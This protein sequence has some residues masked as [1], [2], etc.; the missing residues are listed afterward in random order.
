MARFESSGDA[1]LI[2][3]GPE[4]LRLEAWGDDSLRVRAR[5]MGPIL[6]WDWALLPKPEVAQAVS[7]CI[8]E[9]QMQASITNGWITAEVF[10]DSWFRN[11][12]IVYRNGEGRELL[13]EAGYQGGWK[14]RCRHWKTLSGGCSALKVTFE[15]DPEEK[16]F[17]MGEYQTEEL[18]RKNCMLSLS[19]H[20]TQASV[21][22]VISSAGYGF[23]W[24]NPAVGRA[25]FA[26]NFMEW[27]A[28]VTQQMD[29]W[30]TAGNTPRV[31]EHAFARVVG[32]APMM[33]E[34]GLGFWQS[35]LRYW[36]QEQ[37]LE[38]AREYRR[39]G[40]PL[41]VIACDFFHWRHMG[42]FR[43]EEEFFPDPAAM[44]RELKD[45]GT[46]LMVSVWPQISLRSENY[47]EM[48]DEGLLVRTVR[49]NPVTMQFPEDSVFLDATNPRTRAYVWE[50]CRKHYYDLG[51]RVFWLDEAEPEYGVYDF[52][53]Y[54]YAEGTA[55]E[56]S[57]IYPQRFARAF[58][59]GQQAQGQKE[60]VNLIRC[61]WAGSQRYGA[62]VW[63]GDISSTWES[64]RRQ[65]CAGLSISLAGIPWWNS[66]IG[67]FEDGR[68]EDP[69]FREL[70]VRWFEWGTF[71]P[72]MRLHGDRLPDTPLKRQDGSSALFTG[73]PNEVWSFGEDAYAIMVKYLQLRESMRDYVRLLMQQAHETG[74]PVMRTMFYEFPED[75]ACWVLTDQY[76]FG[77]DML[78]APVLAPG[79]T[80]RSV[81]LPAGAEWIC[82]LDGRMYQGG[83]HVTAGCPIGTIPVF[84]RA[85]THAELVGRNG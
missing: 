11:V 44:V 7:V 75:D 32:T 76:M 55:E 79:I 67:G 27:S 50:K 43:F 53:L 34:F 35:R 69:A 19:Q 57:N 65:L 83:Q 3:V 25:V 78:V 28:E 33:P 4:I 70:L 22:F 17:G 42:D 30:I 54:Q 81:Y 26:R 38:T 51:V 9:D 47:V 68:P 85:G 48:R 52:D 74:D 21:P 18:N 80:R 20:N 46:E 82:M 45:M 13:R 62:L 15:S 63:S 77:P 49:G 59:E 1:L 31:L 61:A 40:L 73:S 29:Y 14:L 8:R 36:N 41:D 72:V 58:Y 16:L 66:D 24:H 64:M 23:F 10:Y 56:V 5:M 71:C 84:F 60:I 12:Q 39:R 6:D 37:L 2:R